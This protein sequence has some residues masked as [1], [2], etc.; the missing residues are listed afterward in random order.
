MVPNIHGKFLRKYDVLLRNQDLKIIWS[1]AFLLSLHFY[2]GFYVL[3]AVFLALKCLYSL[4]AGRKFNV[5][6]TFHLRTVSR[7]TR[8]S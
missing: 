3:I 8:F 7:V 5:H 1:N 2:C 4:D 6:K